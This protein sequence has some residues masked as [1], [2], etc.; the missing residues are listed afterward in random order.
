MLAGESPDDEQDARALSQDLEDDELGSA[1]AS[2]LDGSLGP[3]HPPELVEAELA[4]VEAF[5]RRAEG[6]GSEDSKFKAL[7]QALSFVEARAR[8]GQGA[9]KLVVFTES[10]ITQEYLRTRLTETRLISDDEV[11]LFRGKNDSIRAREA[12]ERWRREVP[13]DGVPPSPEVAV[14]LA[15]VHEFKTRS[16]VF[17]S[18]E[19]GAK[20][21]NLQFCDTVVNYDLPWNPQRIEQRIG[22]CHRYGQRNGVTVINFIARDNE[23]QRLTF[24]ILS[25]KLELF[26]TVLSASDEVLHRPERNADGVLVASLGAEFEQELRRIYER[27][28]T[29]EEVTAALR[30]L[31]EQVD[32]SRRRFEDMHD[33]TAGLIEEHLEAGL[34]SIFRSRK[35]SLPAALAELD[36]DLLTLAESYLAALD[37]GHRR[38]TSDDGSLLIVEPSPSLP[39]E[40]AQGSVAAVGSSAAHTSLHLGHPLIKAAVEEARSEHKFAPARL[41]MPSSAS[42]E[43]RARS[44]AQAHLRVV[45]I[46]L[47]GFERTEQ[48]LPVMVMADGEP[49][50][51][52]AAHLILTEGELRPDD[53]GS[54]EPVPEESVQDAVDLLLFGLQSSLDAAEQERFERAQL[55]AHRFLEDRLLVM[56]RRR[57]GLLERMGELRRRQD[58]AVGAA[59]RT[60]VE[61]EMLRVQTSIDEVDGAMRRLEERDDETFRAFY[62]HIHK[63]RYTPPEVTTLFE[64]GMVLE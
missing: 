9:G 10:L 60:E 2:G 47:D 16:R 41:V 51:T 55:Q 14:R 11:T 1:G 6:L 64:M 63:R 39:A 12:L 57:Q 37:V 31:R 38:E 45:K 23:A 21:L 4:R 13:Q 36:H 19:A 48:I 30:K 20:G 8:Q 18:T 29:L 22:R 43:L 27:S 28:R 62:D 56:K 7:L 54:F 42:P 32:E 24:E 58:S 3:R 17:I 15:L 33:R 5:I 52:D 40:L 46:S 34:Q 26:G 59:A 49:L 44:G 25:Q 50:D 35:R 53:S 61:Q